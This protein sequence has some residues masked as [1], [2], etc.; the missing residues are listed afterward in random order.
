MQMQRP[1]MHVPNEA[2]H[3]PVFPTEQLDVAGLNAF[4]DSIS[5]EG[6]ADWASHTAQTTAGASGGHHLR[7]QWAVPH[8]AAAGNSNWHLGGYNSMQQ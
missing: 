4:L 1:A 5:S 7:Q 3:Q 8:A 2:L 6:Q